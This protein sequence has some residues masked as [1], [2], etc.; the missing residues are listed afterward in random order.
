MIDLEDFTEAR[1]SKD[2]DTKDAMQ[3]NIEDSFDFYSFSSYNIR[4]ITKFII[5][6]H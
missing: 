3:R 1:I 5:N 6:F 2:I 4:S